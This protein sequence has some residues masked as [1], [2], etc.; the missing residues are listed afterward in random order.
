MLKKESLKFNLAMNMIRTGSN[1]LFPIVV[2]PYVVRVLG[3]KG[4]S[5][6]DT[7]NSLIGYLIIIASLGVGIY[8]VREIGK[9][10]G[11]LIKRA[12]ILKELLI[13]N[14]SVATI[15]YIFLFAFLFFSKDSVLNVNVTMILS[16]LIFF[17]S[18]GAD[19]YFVGIE[20]QGFITIRGIIIKIIIVIM[21]FLFV[22][23]ET[24]LLIYATLMM[25][26][27]GISSLVSIYVLI[28]VLKL[29]TYK[30]NLIPH[31][32][33]MANSLLINSCVSYF[34]L[35]DVVLLSGVGDAKE[36]AYYTLPL[37]VFK[38][39]SVVVTSTAMVFLPRVSGL[40]GDKEAFDRINRTSISFILFVSFGL[41]LFLFSFSDKIVFLFGG[42]QFLPSVESLKIL[43]F[44]LILNC[45]TNL[46]TFQVFYSQ[47]IS[48]T[49]SFLYLIS[50]VINILI[51][52]FG[53]KLFGYIAIAYSYLISL[54]VLTLLQIIYNYYYTKS[55]LFTLDQLKY[56]LAFVVSLISTLFFNNTYMATISSLAIYLM[57]LRLTKEK[58]VFGLIDEKLFK[59]DKK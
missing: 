22:K 30:L 47:G 13:I 5:F 53:Y 1:L 36:I 34:G 19:W 35:M 3:V 29:K 24:D 57:I 9:A 16:L 10:K 58:L 51:I 27:V 32:G 26:M 7:A 45:F 55:E 33:P 17:T 4:I 11:D 12:T 54:G 43:A 38:I 15:V 49:I 18:L 28:P 2:F 39:V 56:I 31:L 48:K 59:R 14:L 25:L 20:K 21:V 41:A 37:R 50:I 8:G 44:V 46:M 40:F 42:S 23:D 6:Y 52:V